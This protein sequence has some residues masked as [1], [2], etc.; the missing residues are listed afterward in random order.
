VIVWGWGGGGGRTDRCELS[1][2]VVQKDET[3]I[4]R[5]DGRR[6]L[7]PEV[8]QERGGT[9]CLLALPL[10]QVTLKRNMLLYVRNYA[11][12]SLFAVCC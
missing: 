10:C 11:T 12:L 7:R 5:T 1:Y 8:M 2:E 3:E 4:H 9:G 6:T